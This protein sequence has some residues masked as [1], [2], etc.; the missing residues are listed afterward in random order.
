M[1]GSG[2]GVFQRGFAKQIK[3]IWTN[4]VSRN[5]RTRNAG[6]ATTK[7]NATEKVQSK[8]GSEK[9]KGP[10]LARKCWVTKED[11]NVNTG[12]VYLTKGQTL[13]NHKQEEADH[14]CAKQMSRCVTEICEDGG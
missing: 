1:P 14:E 12:F 8:I 3:R 11:I 4:F 2:K 7:T 6:N 9:Q 5:T 13:I 10:F